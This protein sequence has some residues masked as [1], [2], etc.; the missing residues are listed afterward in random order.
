MLADADLDLVEVP[1]EAKEC[2]N[3]NVL[4]RR[5]G[6]LEL[7]RPLT[8]LAENMVVTD[9]ETLGAGHAILVATFVEEEPDATLGNIH[10][11]LFGRNGH[12]EGGSKVTTDMDGGVVVADNPQKGWIGRLPQDRPAPLYFNALD[13]ILLEKFKDIL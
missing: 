4:A 13:S 7:V 9:A 5:A 10:F 11:P 2:V 3:S 8:L 6:L 1:L 12:S